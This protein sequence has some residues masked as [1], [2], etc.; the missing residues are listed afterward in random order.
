LPLLLRI[1][2]CLVLAANGAVVAHASSGT[3]VAGDGHTGAAASG[4]DLGLACDHTG[5]P[6]ARA[7][8]ADDHAPSPHPKSRAHGPTSPTGCCDGL[9]CACACVGMAQVPGHAYANAATVVA[10]SAPTRA[11]SPR[12]DYVPPRLPP[13]IRPPIG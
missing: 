8:H 4:H 6:A 7:T 11:L 1:L 2:L 13:L 5:T 9:A 12:I 10:R 3:R